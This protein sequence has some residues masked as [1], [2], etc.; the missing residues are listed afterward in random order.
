MSRYDWEKGTITLPRAAIVPIRRAL[1]AANNKVADD[2]LA[3]AKKVWSEATAKEKATP[4]VLHEKVFA[5]GGTRRYLN[6]TVYSDSNDTTRR[7]IAI[8]GGLYV[9]SV[10]RP[11]QKKN[12][13]HLGATATEFRRGEASVTFDPKTGKMEWDTGDNNHAVE[14]A[15]ESWLGKTLFAQLDAVKWTRGTGGW[16]TG[17]DEYNRENDEYGGGQN[18]VTFA[19][20]PI[21]AE[22]HPMKC[23]E[24]TKSDGT[25]VTSAHLSE[26][27]RKLWARQAR[28]QAALAR[29]LSGTSRGKT[30]AKSTAGSFAGR[31][32]APPTGYLR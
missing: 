16:F 31:F 14:G 6:G 26:M 8:L 27:Q 4:H 30:T 29:A 23:R 12:A 28:A 7:A 19:L 18:Y 32:D 1:V 20:G 25:R 11:P 3:L 21:G 13:G 17:N 9:G 2:G 15:H 10:P 5:A 24:F 22:H